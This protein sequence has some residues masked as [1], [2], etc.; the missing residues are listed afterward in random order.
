MKRLQSD[1]SFELAV[2]QEM[3]TH[4]AE[5][6]TAFVNAIPGDKR[7]H[8]PVSVVVVRLQQPERFLND[9]DELDD[10]VFRIIAQ[11]RREKRNQRS[12]F[13]KKHHHPLH[14]A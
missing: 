8:K 6:L 9:L 5:G 4:K 10:L 2:Q 13:L 12:S 1:D 14:V 11:L 7:T 3:I